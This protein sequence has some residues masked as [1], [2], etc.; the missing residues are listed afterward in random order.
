MSGGVVVISRLVLE[1]I[2]IGTEASGGTTR[3]PACELYR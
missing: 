1:G 3:M 2:M